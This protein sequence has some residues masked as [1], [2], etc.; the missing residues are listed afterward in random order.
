MSVDSKYY[1]DYS[2]FTSEDSFFLHYGGF[3]NIISNQAWFNYN[4]F[5]YN[6]KKL[7]QS[8][9]N[10]DISRPQYSLLPLAVRYVSS[11]QSIYVIERPPFQ[12]E[13]DFSVSNSYR[14]RTSPKYLH[15]A[16]I[17]VPW[18]V[19]VIRRGPTVSSFGSGFSFH[20]YFNDSP[21]KSFDDPLVPC[22]LPNSS[23][24]DI[25]MG[26]D[27]LGAS[28]LIA[29]GNSITDIYNHLF[30]S[31]F[32]GWNSDLRTN[33]KNPEYFDPM[34]RKISST[35]KN[36][37]KLSFFPNS[38]KNGTYFK[39]FLYLLSQISLEEHLGYISYTKSQTSSH[40]TLLSR[41]FSNQSW[42]S[43]NPIYG[44]YSWASQPYNRLSQYLNPLYTAD[45][46]YQCS[47]FRLC[48]SDFDSSY[49]P[50]YI[51]NPYIVAMIY[52][53][54]KSSDLTEQQMTLN[55]QEISNYL[56]PISNGV[57]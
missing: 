4:Y 56:Q 1:Y 43:Y 32:S 37:S 23:N 48:I 17:W 13:I 19:S 16:K 15:S 7:I 47:N 46:S 35:G 40:P 44:R 36:A 41:H 45:D 8:F 12:T 30:N 27:S 3:P 28:Q 38:W 2:L 57:L 31:Y 54:L 11:D 20:I 52:K 18:T 26:Q 42:N 29:D 22:Y 34:I 55:H 10:Q 6:T 21:L 33:I 9:S 39:S 25:C 24:G 51:S 14:P 50:Q 5:Y 53:T 49:I